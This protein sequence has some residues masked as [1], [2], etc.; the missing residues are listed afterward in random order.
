[1]QRRLSAILIFFVLGCSEATPPEGTTVAA[2]GKAD[3][4]YDFLVEVVDEVKFDDLLGGGRLEP[5][6]IAA[7]DG[8]YYV[9]FDNSREVLWLDSGWTEFSWILGGNYG[10]GD[11]PDVKDVKD[12]LGFEGVGFDEETGTLS[13]LIETLR[14]DDGEDYPVVVNVDAEGRAA[15]TWWLH[16]VEAA[17]SG[18]EGMTYVTVGDVRY[19]AVLCEAGKCD[20]SDRGRMVFSAVGSDELIDVD[21]P[22]GLEFGDFSGVSARGN[23]LAVVSQESSK[24]WTGWVE[25]ED[26]R[27]VTRTEAVWGLPKKNGKTVYCT[28][29]GVAWVDDETLIAVS[30]QEK[31]DQPSR[32]H[33][34]AES[35]H[36][37][38][39]A[40]E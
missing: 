17:N 31:P 26:G 35:L 34:K 24:I 21:L 22:K 39:L 1:M 9:V 15:H 32:C 33:E 40:S 3:R 18:A 14:H 4:G 12:F 10:L 11:D 27:L 5:S 2:D 37:F 38:L 19:A 28:L 25:L 30:D 13:L 16:E 7:G 6:G 23:R 8:G 20:G 29:E 36:V